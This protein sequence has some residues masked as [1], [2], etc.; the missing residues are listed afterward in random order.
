[1]GRRGPVARKRAHLERMIQA[2]GNIR[3]EGH[4][5]GGAEEAFVKAALESTLKQILSEARAE[6][7]QFNNEHPPRR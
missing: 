2:C 6:L 1:M 7:E 5:N 3:P 4:S